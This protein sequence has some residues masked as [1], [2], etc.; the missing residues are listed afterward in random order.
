M[1]ATAKQ[2]AALADWDKFVEDTGAYST[3][4]ECHNALTWLCV[5]IKRANISY[6]NVHLCTGVF[7]GKDH[8]WLELEDMDTEE[9]VIVDMTVD[10]FGKFDMPYVGPRSPGYVMHDTCALID[11]ERLFEFIQ[12]LG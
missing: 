4:G 3:F 8:S 10:Q 7:A 11:E 9:Q 6:Y 2:I 1:S 12:R 5:Q